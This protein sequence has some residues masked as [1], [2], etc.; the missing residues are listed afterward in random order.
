[1]EPRG[2]DHRGVVARLGRLST[3]GP[4]PLQGHITQLVA[5]HG[6][7]PFSTVMDSA[8]YA[9]SH[10]FYTACGVAAGRLRNCIT[11]PEVGPHFS[12]VLARMLDAWWDELG[13][14]D[15]FVVVEGG[16]GV[17]TLAVS[18]LAAAPRCAPAPRYLMVERSPLLRA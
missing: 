18:I 9:V 6:P 13:Q 17:R 3:P 2:R 5:R 7:L 15:P 8:L 11:P 14:P 16:A 1:T 12:A 10:G 4:T